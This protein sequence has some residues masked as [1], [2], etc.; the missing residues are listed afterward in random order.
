MYVNT[1]QIVHSQYVLFIGVSYAS[2]SCN[3]KCFKNVKGFV[4]EIT[5]RNW[6][7]KAVVIE[8]CTK[9]LERFRMAPLPARLDFN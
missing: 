9:L 8:K 3:E 5:H 4:Y 6:T 2:E 7:L 1:P